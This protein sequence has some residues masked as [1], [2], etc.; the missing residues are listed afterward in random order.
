[1]ECGLGNDVKSTKLTSGPSVLSRE[2][3]S[4]LYVAARDFVWRGE[5]LWASLRGARGSTVVS[6]SIWEREP[7]NANWSK[8]AGYRTR[9]HQPRGGPHAG[10][11]AEREWGFDPQLKAEVAQGEYKG[12]R[13]VLARHVHTAQPRGGPGGC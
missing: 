9:E 13:E 5:Q 3:E 12:A 4:R 10:A 6:I 8:V 7:R 2:P 1:M 11:G